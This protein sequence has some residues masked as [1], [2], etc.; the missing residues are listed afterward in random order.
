[1]KNDD[2]LECPDCDYKDPKCE[3]GTMERQGELC[4]ICGSILH[5]KIEG[6][7]QGKFYV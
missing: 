7:Q 1:M 5:K 3:K 4:P 2:V 6:I